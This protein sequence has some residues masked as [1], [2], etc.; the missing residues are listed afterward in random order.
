M[1]REY[2]EE[3]VRDVWIE[4]LKEE[5]GKWLRDK[6]HKQGV[7]EK[8]YVIV[9][10]NEG[11]CNCTLVDLVDVLNYVKENLPELLEQL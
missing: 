11:G 7:K 10:H 1:I 3:C 4:R 6:H 8:R 9:A 2:A 5:D